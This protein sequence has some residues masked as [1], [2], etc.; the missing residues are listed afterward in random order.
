MK[1]GL[2]SDSHS[3]VDYELMELF[4]DRDEIWHA[5]DFGSLEVV[6]AWRSLEI[7][8]RGVYGN[9]DSPAI[10]VEFDL[11]ARWQVENFKIWMIH[12]GGYPGKYPARIQQEFKT[13]SINLFI[14]GHSH[15]LKVM[16]DPIFHHWHLNPG[17]H[18]RE[19]F[20]QI[21]TALRFEIIA[22]ELTNLDIIELGPRGAIKSK[23][24]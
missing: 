6:H 1:I 16:R 23:A 14:C 3:Y 24:G 20:H 12:I 5:G 11:Q 18:G 7:P 15:I 17:A 22:S 21:R 19:G 9:I 8:I 10:Q 4:S 2:V 13:H